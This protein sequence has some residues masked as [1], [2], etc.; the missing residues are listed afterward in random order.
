MKPEAASR[1]SETA[2]HPYRDVL[3][4][5]S[6]AAIPHSDHSRFRPLPASTMGI[7]RRPNLSTVINMRMP[8][9]LHDQRAEA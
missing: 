6:S 3:Q 8:Q 4:A 5:S 2:I 9:H 1:A 7:S